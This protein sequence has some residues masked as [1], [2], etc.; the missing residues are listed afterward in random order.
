MI[1]QSIKR[2]IVSIAVGLIVLMVV[3]AALSMFMAGRVGL[4]LDELTTK[5][6]P[7]YGHLARMNIRSLERGLALRQMV[8]AKM[9]N[10][11]DEAD[12]SA[13][14]SAF[15]ARGRDVEQEAQAARKLI[16][17]I[18]ADKSTPSD[19]IA[20]ARIENRLDTALNDT[21]RKLNEEISQLISQLQARNFVEVQRELVRVDD[22]RDDLNQKID[23]VRAEML[24]QVYSG[25]G[26]VI[27]D[28]QR[29]I[30]IS[31]IV[32][33]LAAIVGLIVA[34]L[35]SGGI[36]RPVQRLLEGTRAVEAGRLDGSIEVTTPDEIGQLSSAFNRMVG[37]L[38]HNARVRETFGKYI[39]PKV[40]EGLIDRPAL[41]GTEGQRRIM[42]V[43]FCDMKGFTNFSEGATPQGL[44]KVMNRYLSTMSEPI[45]NQ[46]GIISRTSLDTHGVRYADRNRDRRGTG[47]QHRL[48]I[49]DE[50]HGD[51]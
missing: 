46:H 19:I 6:I 27:R 16:L 40:V 48:G 15:E 31:A 45:R 14:V 44:V 34:M 33:A 11:P 21:R 22:L 20:L 18:I 4:L 36:T 24:A 35:V 1:R 5:Y 51:G 8:I 37:Q 43:M 25:A 28:Q 49:H 42:T 47:R 13:R 29:T 39:D 41:A 17:S 38:R 2:Q 50:L 30:W 3:T 32:T 9:E 12:Y 10:P 7:A 23:A 26:T